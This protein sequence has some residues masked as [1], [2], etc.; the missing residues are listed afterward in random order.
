[1]A[2]TDTKQTDQQT[3][4]AEATQAAERENSPSDPQDNDTEPQT[5]ASASTKTGRRTPQP[6]GQTLP[7][8]DGA[9]EGAEVDGGFDEPITDQG[10]PGTGGPTITRKEKEDKDDDFRNSQVAKNFR[11]LTGYKASDILALNERTHVV[12]TT[13]GG[14]YQLNRKG[15]QVRHLQGPPIPKTFQNEDVS[16]TYIDERARTPFT[17]TAAAINASVH[18]QPAFTRGE[19]RNA[20]NLSVAEAEAQLEAARERAENAGTGE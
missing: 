5:E 6:E 1:M 17:G 11:K 19:Q 13:N 12:A 9:R 2:K 7:S 10:R 20:A 4:T 18:E 15:N 16:D 3:A 8:G 14:K